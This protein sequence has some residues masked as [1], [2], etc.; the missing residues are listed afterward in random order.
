MHGSCASCDY[1]N[2]QGETGGQ[3]HGLCRRAPPTV[4]MTA[5]QGVSTRDNPQG[6][7]VV[8]VSYRPQVRALDVCGDW[9]VAHDNS[10]Q[11]KLPL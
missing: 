10:A 5:V 7:Q 1:F 8:P 9:T 11:S 6:I 4:L 3:A 2:R